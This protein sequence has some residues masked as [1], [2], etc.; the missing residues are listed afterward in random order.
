V[1]EA[2]GEPR[3]RLRQL[4]LCLGAFVVCVISV[5]LVANA[6]AGSK[7]Q[8]W[9]DFP[10]GKSSQHWNSTKKGNHRF[11]KKTC[12]DNNP[13]AGPYVASWRLY[14]H[15][16]GPIP[17]EEKGYMVHTVNCNNNNH[18]GVAYSNDTENHYWK[19]TYNHN[20]LSWLRLNGSGTQYWPGG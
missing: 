20:N 14:H 2:M 5:V 3:V 8:A 6:L 9:Q 17:D 1:R 18:S 11:T 19:L 7:N 12:S 16:G 10:N 13:A 15:R 4:G